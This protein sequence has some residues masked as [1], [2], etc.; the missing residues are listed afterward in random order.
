MNKSV[1]CKNN[2]DEDWCVVLFFNNCLLDLYVMLLLE[3]FDLFDY[4][5]VS[6]L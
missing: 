1:V 6:C 2:V 3:C 5:I 4:V